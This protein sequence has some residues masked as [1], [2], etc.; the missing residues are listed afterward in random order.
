M[1]QQDVDLLKQLIKISESI[2]RL[3]Q[4]RKLLRTTK[5]LS[6]SAG[7]LHHPLSHLQR[8]APLER[9]SSTPNEAERKRLMYS[10]INNFGSIDGMFYIFLHIIFLTLSQLTYY[11]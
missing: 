6:H 7:G 10:S 8:R 2:N 11:C 3:R 9:Q 5:S 4:S 1:H